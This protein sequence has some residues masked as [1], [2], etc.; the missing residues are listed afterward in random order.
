MKSYV[1]IGLGRFGSEMA[2]QLYSL[3]EDVLAID[4]IG[5]IGETLGRGIAGLINIFNPSLVIIGGRL[6]VGKKYLM[7]PIKTAVNKYSL[8]RVN[9]DT[10]I[11]YS[12]LGR[13]AAS[14]GN[15]LIARSKYL[16]LF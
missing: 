1:V 5:K 15:C 8:N 16:G 9:S 14:I 4:C 3:G 12:T 11:V 13:R 2:L 7:Y 10:K 6:I